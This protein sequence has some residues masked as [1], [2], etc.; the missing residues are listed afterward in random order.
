M[1]LELQGEPEKRQKWVEQGELP[2]VEL[3][4]PQ[5]ALPLPLEGLQG[6]PEGLLPLPVL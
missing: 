5:A 1:E 2:P 6:E 4:V 3:G